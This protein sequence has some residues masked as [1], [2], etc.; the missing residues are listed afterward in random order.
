MH[1][2]DLLASLQPPRR[3]VLE[4]IAQSAHGACRTIT[5]EGASCVDY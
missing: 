1:P 3:I 2:L 5:D 4:G